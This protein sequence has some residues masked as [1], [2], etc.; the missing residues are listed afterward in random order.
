MSG[1]G[2]LARANLARHLEANPYPGRGLVVGREPDGA[3][4]QVYWVMGRSANS[5]NRVFVAEGATLR[6]EPHDPSAVEDP[7]LIL[8]E[9]M[10]EADGAH[11]VS[12]G[13][14]T[15]TIRDALAAGGSFEAALATRER[16]PDAPNYTPRISGLLDLR[17]GEPHLALSWLKANLADR[18]RT[19]RAYFRPAPP[20]PGLGLGLTTYRGDGHPLPPFEGEP[21]WLPLEG[22][23]DAVLERY[24][25]A[26][27][28]ENRVALAVKRIP[29]GGGAA[30]IRV[31]NRHRPDAGLD[32]A[33]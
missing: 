26:L 6:T 27:D 8:Y 19:D 9:A 23:A 29:S 13:D 21:L 1:V 2:A 24:W 15:R 11:V 17:G 5:R 31:R 12:N 30:S 28:R 22:D 4:L 3:W 25:A 16:E 7:S 32:A 10:L 14:Q 33:L 20:P 18:S